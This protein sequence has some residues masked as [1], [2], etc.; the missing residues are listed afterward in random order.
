MPMTKPVKTPTHDPWTYLMLLLRVR[1]RSV[2]E[3]RQR[4][5]EK[6]FGTEAIDATIR[7][8][9]D[10]DQLDDAAFAKLW[11]RDRMWHHPISRAAVRQELRDKG[12]SQ[13]LIER[14]LLAEYS[15]AREMQLAAELA[16]ARIHKLRGLDPETRRNRAVA[17][18][19]RRGFPRDLIHRV[20]SSMNEEDERAAD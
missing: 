1:P 8:A 11:V 14:T 17:Y 18:L 12:I 6:G 7:R 15:P 4:L 3:A 19:S 2:A 5:S 20:L 10:A 16:E 9:M 13:E